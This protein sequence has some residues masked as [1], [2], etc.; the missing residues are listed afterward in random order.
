MLAPA[1]PATTRVNAAQLPVPAKPTRFCVPAPSCG[2]PMD[3]DVWQPEQV[4]PAPINGRASPAHVKNP[5]PVKGTVFVPDA[6]T[7][8]LFVNV[9][10]AF[11]T[12]VLPMVQLVIVAIPLP[13]VTAGEPDTPPPPDGV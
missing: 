10:L 13:I 6:V 12:P 4:V 2:A 8:R 7:L 1:L 9:P 11:S 3:H 5:V